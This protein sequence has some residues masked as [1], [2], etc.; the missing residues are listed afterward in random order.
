[1]EGQSY[2][3]RPCL[4]GRMEGFWSNGDT[5]VRFFAESKRATEVVQGLRDLHGGGPHVPEMLPP[6]FGRPSPARAIE[7]QTA[8]DLGDPDG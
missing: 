3:L 1:M 2:W 5:S 8:L 7:G 4:N 6:K